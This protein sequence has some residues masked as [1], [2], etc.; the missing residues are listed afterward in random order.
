MKPQ[1]WR[2]YEVYEKKYILTQY[3]EQEC[4]A[5]A[6][7]IDDDKRNIIYAFSISLYSPALRFHLN[8][9]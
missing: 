5:I 6:S 4:A 7:N 1:S 9:V 3:T 2:I 8:G